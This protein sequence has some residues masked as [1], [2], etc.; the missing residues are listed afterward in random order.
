MDVLTLENV[1]MLVSYLIVF[2]IVVT[3]VMVLRVYRSQIVFI[4]T[5]VVDMLRRS[6]YVYRAPQQPEIEPA[7]LPISAP[8]ETETNSFPALSNAGKPDGNSGFHF[9]SLEVANTYAETLLID[10]LAELVL[11]G[12][13]EKSTAIKVGL[14]AA[15]GRAYQSAKEKLEAAMQKQQYP[16]LTASRTKAASAM[17]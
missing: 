9:Q 2:L 12:K 7:D 14:R 11:A 8:M 15:T 4:L 5:P 1:V 3:F 6:A 17:K 10:R 16:A 13:L